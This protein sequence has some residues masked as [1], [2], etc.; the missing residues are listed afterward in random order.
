M[1]N[2]PQYYGIELAKEAIKQSFEAAKEF[3]G[4]L[5]NPSLEEAGGIIQDNIAFW[6]LK[7]QINI[8]LKAKEF[9]NQKGI[10]L[11]HVKKILPKT[12][13]LIL[14]NG[15]LEEEDKI[16]DKWAALLA[17]AAD[18]NNKYSVNPSFAEILKELSPLEVELLDTMF[19]KVNQDEIANKTEI[20]FEKEEVCPNIEESQYAILLDNL[21]RL[22]LCQPIVSLGHTSQGVYPFQLRTYELIGFTQLGYEFVKL[23]RF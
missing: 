23:C 21:F 2:D 3:T 15:S 12:L 17:N 16:Q 18:P 13:L 22:N 19:D 10:D 9:L 14:E 1:C 4:K 6:R 11:K 8:A 5:V 20:F 7:N